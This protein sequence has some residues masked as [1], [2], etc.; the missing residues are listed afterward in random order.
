MKGNGNG[1]NFW[2]GAKGTLNVLDRAYH[3]ILGV[4]YPNSESEQL[5][6]SIRTARIEVERAESIFNELTDDAAIDYAAYNIMAAR[7][8]YSYLI[9]LAKKQNLKL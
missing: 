6:E 5:Y 2:N 4:A 3:E 1:F 9:S 7:A 8:K